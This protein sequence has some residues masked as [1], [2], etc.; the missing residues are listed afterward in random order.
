MS[1]IEAIILG[2]IQGVSEFLPISSSGHLVLVPWVFGWKD[3][4]LAFDVFLHLGTTLAIIFYFWT[5]LWRIFFA[6]IL[7]VVQRKRGFD[8]D[9]L[10]FWWISVG[11][12][13]AV[14]LG[15]SL[16]DQIETYFRSPLMVAFF[17]AF[18]GFLIYWMDEKYPAIR[19]FDEMKTSDAI[20]I[21]LAQACAL[22]P[23]VSRSGSTIAMARRL[24]FQR[25][26]A[27]R[28]SFLLSVPVVLGA[29]ALEGKKI[30]GH[31][32]GLEGEITYWVGGLISSFVFGILSIHLLLQF[33]KH[34]SL[35]VFSW[36]R[37]ALASLIVLMSL[38]QGN[39]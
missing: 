14:I 10:L 6:G 20:W 39:Q 2:G 11:T 25:Q 34:A 3:P 8:L 15:L 24:G 23:G 33:L 4:G 22:I 19:S 38:F 1:L 5:D 21:G 26:I 28:F 36:Y 30:S 17:L 32:M 18:V 35:R 7:S 12:V 37:L 31:L 9:R 29:L 27:A 13:P 16:G